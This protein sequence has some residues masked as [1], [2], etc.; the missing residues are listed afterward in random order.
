MK[1]GRNVLVLREKQK[2]TMEIQWKDNLFAKWS[3]YGPV[4]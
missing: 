2:K 3:F 4:Q 1:S